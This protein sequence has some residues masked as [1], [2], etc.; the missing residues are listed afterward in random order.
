MEEKHFVNLDPVTSNF[1]RSYLKVACHTKSPRINRIC[2][3]CNSNTLCDEFHSFFSEVRK[4][5]NVLK[6]KNIISYQN[7]IAI[8]K[9]AQYLKEYIN[10]F[11]LYI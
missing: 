7:P 8:K 10:V 5:P 6:L 4:R 2:H 9:L 11:Y 1:K 3:F